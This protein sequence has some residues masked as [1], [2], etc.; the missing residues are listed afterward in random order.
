[1]TKTSKMSVSLLHN[2]GLALG[3][4]L[5]GMYEG[6]GNQIEYI[7]LK[8]FFQLNS[9]TGL[10]WSMFNEPASVDD[11]FTMADVI[12]IL[13]IDALIYLILALYIEN[14]WPGQYGIPKYRIKKRFDYVYLFKFRS[15]FYPF[16]LDYWRGYSKANSDYVNEIYQTD[17]ENEP[18]DKEI[19]VQLN[20]ISKVYNKLKNKYLIIRFFIHLQTYSFLFQR[21]SSVHAVRNLSMNIYNNQLTALLGHNGAGKKMN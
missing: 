5:I 10:Q 12:T 20:H 17:F 2:I 7:F 11:N 21:R 8:N 4:Q 6:K 13:Y 15:F 14:I 18:N 9:G 19:G 1:M 3:A 16:T